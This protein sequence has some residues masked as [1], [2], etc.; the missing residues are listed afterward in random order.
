L[1]EA[2]DS[3]VRNLTWLSPLA[4][5][6]YAEYRDVDFLERLGVGHLEPD[7]SVFWPERGPQWDALAEYAGGGKLLVEAKAHIRELFSHCS[8]E[9]EISRSRIKIALGETVEFV[10][11]WPRVAWTEC[12]YQLANRVAHLYFLRN[13]GVNAKLL[14]V[15]FVGDE[16]MNGP[17]SEAE[18]Q[19]AY[20]VVWGVLG[21][22]TRHDLAN[23]IVEIFPEVTLPVGWT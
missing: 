9:N 11:A 19:A 18:W 22:P 7:L 23:H 17:R 8:A 12:F 21:V 20:D 6:D 14:L 15:N 16:R 13:H 10:K 1:I 5:D 2:K 3:K 4:D